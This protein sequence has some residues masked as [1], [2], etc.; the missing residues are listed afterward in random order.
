MPAAQDAEK[1][2]KERG[3]D[4]PTSPHR[5]GLGR[6]IGESAAVHDMPSSLDAPVLAEPVLGCGANAGPLTPCVQTL[7]A[8]Q[9]LA[10]WTRRG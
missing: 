7:E 5:S 10:L 1:H 8:W 3:E 2:R 4:E 6:H 9:I